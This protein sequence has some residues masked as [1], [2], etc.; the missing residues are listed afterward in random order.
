MKQIH[1]VPTCIIPCWLLVIIA[2]F[3]LALPRTAVV[4]TRM[5]W[6][7]VDEIGW[8]EPEQDCLASAIIAGHH[9]IQCMNQC[10]VTT[11]QCMVE[12]Q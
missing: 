11:V 1:F 6:S 2:R 12:T 9:A 5:F 10:S 7:T 3:E 8:Y 4:R